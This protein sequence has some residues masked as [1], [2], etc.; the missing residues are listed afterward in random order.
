VHPNRYGSEVEIDT[1][2]RSAHLASVSISGL[3]AQFWNSDLFVPSFVCDDSCDG[4]TLWAPYESS[5]DI[6]TL[7]NG[8]YKV[9]TIIYADASSVSGVE[10]VDNVTI[11]GF[12]VCFVSFMKF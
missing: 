12:T 6:R 8:R 3:L 1:G 10:Y 7:V 9:F 5:T 11:V 2:S 4:H